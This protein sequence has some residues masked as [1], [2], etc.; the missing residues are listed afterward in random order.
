MTGAAAE[1]F[2]L[3]RRGRLEE[4]YAADVTV[5]DWEGVR[6]HGNA[7]GDASPSGV[8]H[9]FVNGERS[10]DMGI[11]RAVPGAGQVLSP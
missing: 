2:R 10:L 3:D 9:V 8:E 7:T 4:G 1:R 6:D 11:V 5:F